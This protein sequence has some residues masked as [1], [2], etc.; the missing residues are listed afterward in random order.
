LS[1]LA[2][3]A[4]SESPIDLAN[5]HFAALGKLLGALPVADLLALIE[6]RASVSTALD[7]AEQAA[8]IVA[9]AFP[10]AAITAREVEFGLEALHFVLG[11]A[12]LGVKPFR[13]T[14]G[15]NPLRGGFEGARGHI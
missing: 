15:Q 9:A 1:S 6:G 3:A 2:D 10:P 14:P 7:L 4:S 5:A 13:V 12:G 11:A 8:R